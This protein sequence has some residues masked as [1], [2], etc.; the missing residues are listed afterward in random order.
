MTK[1]TKSEA[2]KKCGEIVTKMYKLFGAEYA[3]AKDYEA[4]RRV[5]NI[6]R[7]RAK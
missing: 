3:T 2:K 5:V 4:V 6:I 1:M 7:N